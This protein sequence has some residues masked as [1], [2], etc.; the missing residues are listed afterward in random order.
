MNPAGGTRSRT[1]FV[2]FV[3]LLILFAIYTT[4]FIFRTSFVVDGQRYF[5]LFDDAMVSMRY[6]ANLASGEGLVWNRGGDRVEGFTNPLWVGY[7][8]FLHLMPIENRVISVVVQITSAVLLL[9]NLVVV[10]R[11]ARLVA[12]DSHSTALAAVALTAFYLPLNNWSL[13]GME[14]GLLALTV[15][16]SAWRAGRMLRGG[17]FDPWP[18]VALSAATWVRMDAV[19]P[20]L[21]ITTVMALADRHRSV[22]H[23]TTGLALSAVF[24]ATQT[25]LRYMYFGDPLP[26]TYYLKLTG[27]P[28]VARITSG[29]VAALG[30]S[31]HMSWVIFIAPWFVALVRGGGVERLLLALF[32]GQLGYSIYV[33]GDAWEFWGG[34]NRY[35][36]VAMPVFFVLLAVAVTRGAGWLRGWSFVRTPRYAVASLLVAGCL[37]NTNALKG[38]Q[39]LRQWLLLDPPLH[40][41]DAREL[42]SLARE[43]ERMTTADATIAVVRAGVLPYFCDR[44]FIDLLGKTDRHTARVPMRVSP[45]WARYYNFYPGHLKWDY[46]RSIGELRPDI[47]TAVWGW[48]D[49]KAFLDDYQLRSV[50]GTEVWVRKLSPR[51]R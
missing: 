25:F 50:A 1:E 5:A 47:I 38:P 29:A 7:M 46:A 20:L 27:Y 15:T 36:S 8:A 21:V 28:V 42:V 22:R 31:F 6:A 34:S 44:Q 3:A 43:I 9:V 17:Q 48:E 49:A 41:A 4:A 19:V 18:Y 11:L 23:W 26:N 32:A 39:S 14:V 37:V 35:I 12:P 30:F 33:G 2:A 24:L 16:W 40:A 45:G 51:V 10:R 13:Q